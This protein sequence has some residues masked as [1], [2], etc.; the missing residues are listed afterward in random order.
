MHAGADDSAGKNEQNYGTTTTWNFNIKID[1]RERNQDV[2]SAPEKKTMLINHVENDGTLISHLSQARS[3]LPV[4][5]A[6]NSSESLSSVSTRSS[7]VDFHL[8]KKRNMTC[9]RRFMFIV[10]FFVLVF[11]SCN[12]PM[13]WSHKHQQ[14]QQRRRRRDSSYIVTS[15]FIKSDHNNHLITTASPSTYG[16]SSRGLQQ[17]ND[18]ELTCSQHSSEPIQ[19]SAIST[20]LKVRAGSSSSFGDSNDDG[21]YNRN[22]DGY[23][24][25]EENEQYYASP[26][27]FDKSGS[28]RRDQYYEDDDYYGR[29]TRSAGGG[30]SD[31]SN[32]YYDDEGRYHSGGYDD[33]YDGRGS[34]S[35][36]FS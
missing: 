31:E 16:L 25:R 34:A 21:Y 9:L 11:V 20:L 7:R 6:I 22:N 32:G 15:A 29:G 18:G 33:N 13:A 30:R 8:N 3:I 26:S 23:G 5:Q 36:S 14:Q 2:E 17:E 19:V 24:D 1:T 27:S 12:V 10:T 28:G 4:S 35:V